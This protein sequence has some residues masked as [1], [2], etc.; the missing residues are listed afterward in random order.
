MELYLWPTLVHRKQNSTKPQFPYD[1]DTDMPKKVKERLWHY[2]N[3]NGQLI[4]QWPNRQSC[5]WD[6]FQCAR[7]GR[8]TESRCLPHKP[9]F[10]SQYEFMELVA[11]NSSLWEGCRMCW[12]G[13]QPGVIELLRHGY[14]ESAVILRW[15]RKWQEGMCP[16]KA[17]GVVCDMEGLP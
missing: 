6:K 1:S 10:Q 15:M 11:W 8:G 7:G 4:Y 3:T 16:R 9:F 5:W 14:I 2:Q 17:A 13:G 12:G